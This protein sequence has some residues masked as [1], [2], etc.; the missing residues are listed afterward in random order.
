MTLKRHRNYLFKKC[1][2][3]A[4]N[5]KKLKCFVL[6]I[7]SLF[8]T[9][10]IVSS[11]YGLKKS[12]ILSD[13]QNWTSVEKNITSNKRPN[14]KSR[15]IEIEYSVGKR[16]AGDRVVFTQSDVATW[17]VPDKYYKV[18]EYYGAKIT[19]VIIKTVQVKRKK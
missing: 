14:E 4:A 16:V 18:T 9:D 12:E 17:P 6:C 7:L 8:L 2:E 11:S 15:R 3:G 1:S 5:M 10:F 13:T 19:S